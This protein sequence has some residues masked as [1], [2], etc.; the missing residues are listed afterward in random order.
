MTEIDMP[1]ETKKVFRSVLANLIDDE[2]KYH[3]MVF[4]VEPNMLPSTM[5]PEKVILESIIRLGERGLKPDRDNV[6]AEVASVG[7]RD[8]ITTEHVDAILT[9]RTSPPD[10]KSMSSFL[11]G[12]FLDKRATDFTTKVAVIMSDPTKGYHEKF[13]IAK[14]LLDTVNL[15]TQEVMELDY[16]SI[17]SRFLMNQRNIR[18][19][20]LKGLDAGVLLPWKAHKAYFP[21]LKFGEMTIITARTGFGKSTIINSILDDAAYSQALPMNALLI[22]NETSID[23]VIARMMSRNTMIKYN[24]LVDGV[25]DFEDKESSAYQ[26]IKNYQDK[27]KQREETHGSFFIAHEVQMD[28]SSGLRTIQKYAHISA[29]SGRKLVFGVDYISNFSKTGKIQDEKEY[30]MYERFAQ[31]MYGATVANN[32]HAIVTAQE[33]SQGGIYASSAVSQKGQLILSVERKT[34]DMPQ[35]APEDIP[36]TINGVIQRDTLGEPRYWQRKG[37][38]HGADLILRIVKGNDTDR[39]HID[40]L[41]EGPYNKIWQNP[42]QINQLKNS[43]RL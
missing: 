3:Q 6:C 18:D 30:Q 38:E 41:M 42:D 26:A 37:S 10:V 7:L 14:Q 21:Y 22:N 13:N 15:P 24:D 2:Y 43:G 17:F 1:E 39:G 27:V 33:N 31:S 20:K 25:V 34:Y 12:F 40:C 5:I 4:K 28:I 19:L 16:R 9:H 11:E 8:K 36:F 23:G 35:G 29:L 32:C